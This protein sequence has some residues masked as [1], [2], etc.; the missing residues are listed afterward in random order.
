MPETHAPLPRGLCAEGEF[1]ILIITVFSVQ[2][3]STSLCG[4][5]ETT[6]HV[7]ITFIIGER[8]LDW[9]ARGYRCT[10]ERKAGNV[11]CLK[12]GAGVLYS[13]INSPAREL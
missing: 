7:Y 2:L 4:Q 9:A 11:H 1:G 8:A 13:C 5:I 10:R 12:T 3:V 6:L